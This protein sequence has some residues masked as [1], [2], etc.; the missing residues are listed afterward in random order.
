MLV[1]SIKIGIVAGAFVAATFSVTEPK[2]AEIQEI[3]LPD[4]IDQDAP[5]SLQMYKHIKA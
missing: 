1:N 3:R 2:V 5:P 4:S